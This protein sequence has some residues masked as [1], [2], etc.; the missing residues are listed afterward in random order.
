MSTPARRAPRAQPHDPRHPVVL[1]TGASQGIGRATAELYAARGARLVL[2]AR[3]AEALGEV[4]EVCVELG[5]EVEVVVADV[6][7]DAQVEHAVAVALRRFGRLDVCVHVA[8]ISAHGHHTDTSAAVFAQVISTNLVGAA[9]VARSSLTVF[10]AQGTG[11]LVVV[12]SVLGRVAV[13]GMGAYVASKWGLRGLVRVLQQENRD[14]PGVTITSVA[15]G[16]VRTAIYSRSLGG[17]ERSASPPPPSTS[18]RVVARSIRSAAGRHAREH[19]VD[20]LGGLGNK[21]L[22]AAFTLAPAV[23]DRLIGPL[24]RTLSAST[25]PRPPG[26]GSAGP[27]PAAP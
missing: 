13:P 6:A 2:C 3:S 23:Y 5:A 21:A 4:D 22:G 26:S 12:G 18:P 10:R 1:V 8:G 17:A 24:M 19:D 9:N 14:R 20:A 11:V 16:S 15:P 27:P 25:D 7:D